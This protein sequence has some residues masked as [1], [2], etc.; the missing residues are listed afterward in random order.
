MVSE[1]SILIPVYN[2]NVSALVDN[3]LSQA[4]QLAI[5]FEIRVYDDGSS[6]ETLAKNQSLG[7]RPGVIYRELPENLG[8]SQIRYLMAQEAK[9]NQLLFLDNDVLP[10]YPDFLSRYLQQFNGQV[11]VGG[12]AYQKKVLAGTELR[13]KYGKA[14]EE[15]PAVQRQK[16]PYQRIFSS[17][18]LV[19]RSL[20][21]TY[22]PRKEV[23]GYGHEDTL[24]A[25]RLQENKIPV[26][27]IDNP[28]WHLGLEP[29]QLFLLKT[30]EAI[31]NLARLNQQM[32][33]GQES[34]LYK[35]YHSLKKWKAD[36]F[37][38]EN[39]SWLL[40]MIKRNLVSRNPSLYLFDLYRLLLL[41]RY[42]RK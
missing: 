12:V 34:R 39:S 24:F 18:F 42:L 25:H 35:L 17:N 37:L 20:F 22:F 15:A 29:A 32:N 23:R 27:H 11:T 3:L 19:D 7:Q 16:T 10:R 2:Q 21:L 4:S 38:K 36:V 6:P 1:I 5:S 31:L 28:V 41:D 26:M 13:W 40:P 8:R 14:R 9:Y 30:N 33:L